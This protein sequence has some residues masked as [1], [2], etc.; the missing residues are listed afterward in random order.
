MPVGKALGVILACLLV[1]LSIQALPA[2]GAQLGGLCSGLSSS[3]IVA[4]MPE[5]EFITV[6]Q[7]RKTYVMGRARCTPLPGWMFWS[8]RAA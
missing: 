5:Q 3:R 8:P 4:G 2:L 1:V 7:L 6:R